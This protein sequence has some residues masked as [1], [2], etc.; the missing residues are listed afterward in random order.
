VPLVFFGHSRYYKLALVQIHNMT[1]HREQLSVGPVVLDSVAAA[2]K[3]SRSQG[4][5]VL[6]SF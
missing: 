3:A 5:R 4:G 2:D 6:Q 1:V